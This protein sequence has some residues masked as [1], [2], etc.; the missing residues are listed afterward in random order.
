MVK[1]T[2][3]VSPKCLLI[4]T[5]CSTDDPIECISFI[6][7][8]AINCNLFEKQ[9]RKHSRTLN[10]CVENNDSELLPRRLQYL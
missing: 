4:E 1:N 6:F 2:K 8:R 10:C 5:E 9:E 7:L 3:G